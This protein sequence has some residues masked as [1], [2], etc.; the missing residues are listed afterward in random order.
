VAL[1]INGKL[2]HKVFTN[3][4]EGFWELVDWVKEQ[5]ADQNLDAPPP[6]ARNPQALVE[7]RY[8]DQH[9]Y[10]EAPRAWAKESTWL[11]P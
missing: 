3:N 5:E 9:A 10:P 6:V 4:Q 11:T 1:L 8:P 2:K 7:G